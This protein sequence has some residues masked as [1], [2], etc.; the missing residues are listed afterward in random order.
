[1]RAGIFRSSWSKNARA[2]IRVS[3]IARSGSMFPNRIT[4]SV[5][6]GFNRTAHPGVRPYRRL[7]E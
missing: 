6:S 1:M 2:I 4:S 7:A 3:R 5:V